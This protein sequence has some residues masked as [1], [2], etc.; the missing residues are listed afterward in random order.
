MWR[1][2]VGEGAKRVRII[3]N[4]RKRKGY[5]VNDCEVQIDHPR[6]LWLN[7]VPRWAINSVVECHLHTVEVSGSNP[8]SPTINPRITFLTYSTAQNRTAH[9]HAADKRQSKFIDQSNAA[10][11]LR[12]ILPLMTG[13]W[14]SRHRASISTKQIAQQ[15]SR[16]AIE[17]EYEIRYLFDNFLPAGDNAQSGDA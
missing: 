8:L 10:S 13:S 9:C 4:G 1:K 3:V 14:V 7:A 2:P 5:I 16:W 15:G 17:N 11:G 12:V 6:C